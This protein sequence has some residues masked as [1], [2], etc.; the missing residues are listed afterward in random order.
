MR[1]RHVAGWSQ[2]APPV[3]SLLVDAISSRRS[4]IGS[5]Y[6]HIT[7]VSNGDLILPLA[8]QPEYWRAKLPGTFYYRPELVQTAGK[9]TWELVVTDLDA[10]G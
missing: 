5:N 10:A 1:S 2:S 9:D 6:E 7:R 4:A 8:V 3:S